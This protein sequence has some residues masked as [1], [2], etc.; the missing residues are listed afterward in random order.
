MNKTKL[1]RLSDLM[2]M[3][4]DAYNSQVKQCISD[5]I[6]DGKYFDCDLYNYQSEPKEY[7]FEKNGYVYWKVMYSI[8]FESIFYDEEFGGGNEGFIG[9][10]KWLY[11]YYLQGKAKFISCRQVQLI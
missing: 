7:D 8:G 11:N 10:P 9:I 2:C 5:P 3:I 6:W 1:N 4:P